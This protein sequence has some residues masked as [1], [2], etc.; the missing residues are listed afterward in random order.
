MSVTAPS[1]LEPSALQRGFAFTHACF[2]QAQVLNAGLELVLEGALNREALQRAADVL[3]RRHA[4]LRASFTE[5][6][7]ALAMHIGD[8]H[9]QPIEL[10]DLSGVAD[11]AERDERLRQF[12]HAAINHRFDLA[13]FPLLRLSLA[14]VTAH[15]HVLWLVN[16]HITG[17]ATSLFE[18]YPT[19]LAATYAAFEADAGASPP[20]AA[21]GG[22]YPAFLAWEAKRNSGTRLNKQIAYWHA[23]LQGATPT[24]LALGA[25]Q[26]A[27]RSGAGGRITG[28]P[29]GDAPAALERLARELSVNP[30]SILLAA[31]QV[32]LRDYVG[33]PDLVIGVPVAR[34]MAQFA[35]VY[36]PLSNTLP[37][38]SR[39]ERG[40]SFAE[41]V[42]RVQQAYYAGFM[43]MDVS[44]ET[45]GTVLAAEDPA[46]G[47]LSQVVFNLLPLEN[48]V[49]AMGGLSVAMKRVYPDAMH[50]DLVAD[51][52]MSP[53]GL[54][55]GV[56]YSA[57]AMSAPQARGM[58]RRYEA[59]LR[60]GLAAP[61]EPL[62]ALPDPEEV[63]RMARWRGTRA[64]HEVG[65]WLPVSFTKKALEAPDAVALSGGTS[66]TS[67][68]LSYA[69]LARRAAELGAR[70][71]S[72]G[73]GPG[74]VLVVSTGRAEWALPALWAAFETGCTLGVLGPEL[75][76]GLRRRLLDDP[77]IGM[78]VEEG[79]SVAP[80]QAMLPPANVAAFVTLARLGSATPA[81]VPG[82]A[83]GLLRQVE[84]VGQR[85]PIGPADCVLVHLPF[86]QA[87]WLR[88]VCC[89]LASGATIAAPPGAHASRVQDLQAR[90]RAGDVTHLEI[91][92]HD[93]LWL[94][95][96]AGGV[97]FPSVRHVL[98]D[99][100]AAPDEARARLAAS[101]PSARIEYALG[102]AQ[103]GGAVV[104]G[105]PNAG[106]DS[107]VG[108]AQ[109]HLWDAERRPVPLGVVGRLYVTGSALR[110][111]GAFDEATD[112]GREPGFDTGL[113]A[114]FRDD[115]HLMSAGCVPGQQVFRGW[116]L[117]LGAIEAALGREPGVAD[118]ALVVDGRD[119]GG[120]RLV[121]YLA[122]K[123]GRAPDTQQLSSVLREHLPDDIVVGEWR[124][125][126][127]R[128][129]LADG[130]IDRR[131]LVEAQRSVALELA[132]TPVEEAL[133]EIWKSVLRLP[134][135]GIHDNF[136]EIGGHSIQSMEMILQ[137]NNRGIRLEPGLLFQHPTIAGLAAAVGVTRDRGDAEDDTP[138]LALRT[139]GQRPRLYFVHSMPGDLLG[140]GELV[141][142]L[143]PDQP[144]YGFHGLQVEARYRASFTTLAGHYATILQ[145]HHAG[146]YHLA[147]WCYGGTLAFEIARQLQARG[148]Q[149]GFIGL[150]EAWPIQSTLG[151]LRYQL[152]VIARGRAVAI[153]PLRAP[154][155]WLRRDP[156]TQDGFRL[157]ANEGPF[158][159]RAQ[160]YEA[161]RAAYAAHRTKRLGVPVTLVR[162][163]IGN[164]TKIYEDD[165]GW[166][167]FAAS[168]RVHRIE[169]T[170]ETMIDHPDATAVA[171]IIRDGIDER[172]RGQAPRG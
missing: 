166:H 117:D 87:S 152:G 168:V 159:G 114:C 79:G 9:S 145:A 96:Q 47:A 50:L 23:H 101:F 4:Q 99:G 98:A 46:G 6:G 54:S 60:R 38:R 45:L 3:L 1:R 51:V 5:L 148:A 66:T 115:G 169:S 78:V 120:P 39:S 154:G 32:V 119:G 140:Y 22:D 146:P 68:S 26:A 149:V 40:E 165:Y 171:R 170:H 82:Y 17:D 107:V 18:L 42:A 65:P 90:L 106:P 12:A 97:E 30:I 126:E 29:M 155:R 72:A 125:V 89:A 81:W 31:F 58:L 52:E 41:L 7:G 102:F 92:T 20:L 34:R 36:G 86:G 2:P 172:E 11:A 21:V 157:E 162:A 33:S 100:F 135:V 124:S 69:E 76:A 150:L 151:R 103:T 43:H 163:S 134:E 136:F 161:N 127:R 153:P 71:R 35:Q 67:G 16:H 28:E 25:R 73:A 156:P 19:E 80:R 143:G 55:V 15:R 63:E 61:G 158:T 122:H 85:R 53:A 64:S 88:A 139:T 95:V 75:P 59:A 8:T 147:G 164:L 129:L 137:A 167:N 111:G 141:R 74:T 24:R 62:D 27:T 142:S 84:A 94:V 138:L 121:G 108:D 130:K 57:D 116:T 109:L 131:R 104:I 110:S 91:T 77:R 83:D 10:L 118:C 93:L 37:I 132:R 14:K 112:P 13:E 56:H 44:F 128:S 160:V 48:R 105:D 123:T 113:R 70:I 144:C 49:R 133:V